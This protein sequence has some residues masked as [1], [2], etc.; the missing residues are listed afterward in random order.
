ME[1]LLKVNEVSEILQMSPKT[2]YH[3]VQ[4]RQIPFFKVYAARGKSGLVRFK[5]SDLEQ[6]LRKRKQGEDYREIIIS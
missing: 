3:W 1:K 6:W 2:I 4:S 5:Q